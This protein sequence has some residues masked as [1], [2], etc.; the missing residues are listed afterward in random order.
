MAIDLN[1]KHLAALQTLCEGIDGDYPTAQRAHI[2][3][4]ARSIAGIHHRYID[5]GTAEDIVERELNEIIAERALRGEKTV[6]YDDQTLPV[7]RHA[8]FHRMKSMVENLPFT[9]RLRIELPS[10]PWLGQSAFSITDNITLVQGSHDFDGPRSGP[11]DGLPPFEAPQASY[12][13]IQTMGYATQFLDSP[14]LAEALSVAKRCAFLLS[15]SGTFIEKLTLRKARCTLLSSQGQVYRVEAPRSLGHCFG[16]L[17]PD[18]LKLVRTVVDNDSP[19]AMLGSVLELAAQTDDQ[20][21]SAVQH[22]FKV[23]LRFFAKDGHPDFASISAAME[24]Y[25]DSVYADNQTFSYLAACIGLEALLGSDDFMDDMSNRL[26]DRY[27]FLL[28][29][30]RQEREELAGQYRKVLKVRGKLVHAKVARLSSEDKPYLAR[31]QQLLLDA[32]GKELDRILGGDS[33]N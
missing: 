7:L 10:F 23:L 16:R 28:G 33:K 29:R 4:V 25:H 12:L 5:K 1:G 27:G 2:D 32:L 30:S 6:P 15:A 17:T 22:Q 13:E 20:K 8:Y 3:A 18:P 19:A 24:W 21:R 11:A 26:A 14:A 9:Y 31:A